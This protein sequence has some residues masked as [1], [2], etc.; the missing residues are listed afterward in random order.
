M[1]TVLVKYKVIKAEILSCFIAIE[2]I[3]FLVFKQPY[4][5]KT[6]EMC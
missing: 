2:Q 1:K 5:K 6:A 3:L 4:K